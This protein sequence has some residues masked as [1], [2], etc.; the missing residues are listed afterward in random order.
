MPCPSSL[1]PA[2]IEYSRT[3]MTRAGIAG[4]STARF[5]QA[6][7]PGWKIAL[8]M[9]TMRCLAWGDFDGLTA[10]WSPGDDPDSMVM[11]HRE[12][13]TLSLQGYGEETAEWLA[14]IRRHLDDQAATQVL[15]INGYDLGELGGIVNLTAVLNTGM[16]HR[17]G[18]DLEVTYRAES[19]DLPVDAL[20][21]LQVTTELAGCEQ[22]PPLETTIIEEL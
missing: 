9:V 8:P 4:A 7:Q 11:A 6:D 10:D 1:W 18:L 15:A 2:L 14:A 20:E 16:Q 17:Y 19:A 22:T 12:R 3:A 5:V 21:S 13:G